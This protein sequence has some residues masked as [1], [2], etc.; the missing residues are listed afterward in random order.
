MIMKE[1]VWEF[2]PFGTNPKNKITEERQ[3]IT[4]INGTNFRYFVPKAAPFFEEGVVV[5]HVASGT[6]LTKGV[7][8][9]F[10]LSYNQATQQVL[11]PVYGA[12]SILNSQFTGTFEIE[13]HTMGGE[14][15]LDTQT[16]TEILINLITDPRVVS[17]E[18]IVDPPVVFPPIH[19]LQPVSDFVNYDNL[20]AAMEKLGD[21]VLESYEL[22]YPAF[23]RH[24]ED[25]SNPH[26]TTKADIGLPLTPNAR[27]ATLEEAADGARFDVLM[28]PRTVSEMITRLNKETLVGHVADKNNPH[29]VT[30]DQVELGLVP[31]AGWATDEQAIDKNNFTSFLNPAQAWKAVKAWI[32][33]PFAAHIADHD[34]P[35]QVTKNHIGLGLTP[36]LGLS[37]DQ[38]AA[39]GSNDAGLLTPRLGRVLIDAMVGNALSGHVRNKENPHETTKKHVGLEFTPNSSW[40]DEATA[41]LPNA[42]EGFMHPKATWIAIAAAMKAHVDLSNPH[43]TTKKDVGLEYTPNASWA[44]LEQILGTDDESM[45]FVNQKVMRDAIAAMQSETVAGHAAN[46]ENPHGTTKKHVGLEFTPNYAAASPEDLGNPNCNDKLVVVGDVYRILAATSNT[47]V[48]FAANGA[49][50]L[51]QR[52]FSLPLTATEDV[53]LDAVGTNVSGVGSADVLL[54]ITACGGGKIEVLERDAYTSGSEWGV[55]VTQ[56]EVELWIRSVPNRAPLRVTQRVKGGS[57]ASNVGVAA[58][59]LGYT[60][61]APQNLYVTLLAAH[62]AA[63]S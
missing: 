14:F 45:A 40:C 12:I 41:I 6:I 55:V 56:T 52:L 22:F 63:I 11:K 21:K 28:S 48:E 33:D 8:Y 15:T 3:V 16:I 23:T 53:L 44:T 36:N 61:V 17:W 9:Q 59:P 10:G 46:R 54:R 2:D 32:I 4:E 13:Y 7:D 62:T 42:T 27:F 34:N 37:T 20:V 29:G 31:N 51:Y 26:G 39:E 38:E 25:R 50:Q 30:K 60:V 35:H 58:K 1:F 18:R 47:T 24:L 49:E 19:H 57:F 5:K 43:G